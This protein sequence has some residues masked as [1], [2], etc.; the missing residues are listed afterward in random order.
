MPGENDL[1]ILLRTLS[2]ALNVGEFVFCSIVKD[3]FVDSGEIVCSFRERE[4]TSIIVTKQVADR[5]GLSYDV[6]LSWITLN[7]HSSL[8]AVGLT[9]AFSKALADAGISCNVVAGYHHDHIFVPRHDAQKAMTVLNDLSER[10]RT[11]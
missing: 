4:G 3:Q 5:F 2:P 10:S 6:V 8:E 1:A 7:V 11:Q 9:A